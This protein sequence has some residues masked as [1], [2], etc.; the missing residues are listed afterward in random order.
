MAH[1]FLHIP[2]ATLARGHHP[3]TIGVMD[4]ACAPAWTRPF[5]TIA[6][7]A[8]SSSEPEEIRVGE[9]LDVRA[10]SPAN[11]VGHP[12]AEI[13]NPRPDD[14]GCE[15][16]I[17]QIR[18][19]EHR[20]P[21]DTHTTDSDSNPASASFH[22]HFNRKNLPRRGNGHQLRSTAA[23]AKALFEVYVYARSDTRIDT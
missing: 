19:Q 8:R 13:V 10:S 12:A 11:R 14:G 6:V 15:Q 16:R 4:C 17:V 20:H 9:L 5:R 23:A 18:Q 7:S 1:A 22:E 2:S 21:I 3:P